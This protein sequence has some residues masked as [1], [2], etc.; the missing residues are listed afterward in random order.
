[1]DVK[2]FF[3]QQKFVL[4]LGP[5]GLALLLWLFVVS[6][7]V[8]TV[9]LNMPIEGRNLPARKALKEEVPAYAQVKLKGAGRDLFKTILLKRFV[10]DFKLVL[11]LERISEE[12][13]FVLNDYFERYPQKVVIAPSLE[14]EYIEVIYPDSVFISLDEYREKIVP[15]ALDLE[16]FP[17]SGYTIV[18]TPRIEP[19][20]IRIA[21]SRK[22][23]DFIQAV[24]T[25]AD[26]LND[27]TTQITK[28]LTL[29][30]IS[31]KLLEYDPLQVNVKVDIQ[32]IAERILSDVPVMVV[33]QRPDV[34]VFPSPQTVSLTVIGGADYIAQLNPED[35][36]V[37]IDFT[38]RWNPEKIW[39][40]P[41]IAVPQDV[42]EWMNLSPRNIELVVTRKS[43]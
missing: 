7:N 13:V 20:T 23:V 25:R 19:E 4:A 8:Y 30:L 3:N 28:T 33:N 22:M 16:I 10:S 27:V 26:T 21:G 15:V 18:G 2:A 31:E 12:Y 42:M 32:P 39:Y 24:P 35:V 14:V 6:E 37:S 5:I 41:E 34:R 1:M 29:E 40:A 17:A 9:V 11:D 36:R 43:Q 38:K